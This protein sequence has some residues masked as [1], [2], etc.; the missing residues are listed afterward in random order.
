[1]PAI[2]TARAQWL[3]IHIIP[4]EPQLRRWLKRAAP[5]SLE[6][7][8]LIQEAYAKLAGLP[9]ISNI[10][11]P[12]AYLYQTVKRL[13][14]DHIRR[15]KLVSIEAMAEVAQPAVLEESLTPERILSGRQELERLYRAI[16]RLPTKCR[17]VFLMR[18]FDDMPQKA[19]A[20]QLRVSENTVEKWM[21]RAL[22]MIL[23][24]L[25]TTETD[26]DIRAGR[27]RVADGAKRD[28]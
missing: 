10:T 5:H 4:L 3:A 22:R 17:S 7:D 6:A 28:A 18:K 9:T 20:A 16:A 21:V 19:I 2:S 14:L 23:E 1:M 13:I 27:D 24:D 12:K 25:K 8:D 15:S 11:H 26:F